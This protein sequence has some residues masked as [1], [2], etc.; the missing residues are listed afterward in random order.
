MLKKDNP[1]NSSD[2]VVGGSNE[3][4]VST[5]NE[6]SNMSGTKITEEE[7]D[8]IDDIRTAIQ[9]CKMHKVDYSNL[10]LTDVSSLRLL[11]KR[12]LL[13]EGATRV[14]K[15]RCNVLNDL[16]WTICAPCIEKHTG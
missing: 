14:D 7:I 10:K 9:T 13:C 1:V 12:S 4:G 5:I 8:A 11:L 15:I 3:D 16:D 2:E 6:Q